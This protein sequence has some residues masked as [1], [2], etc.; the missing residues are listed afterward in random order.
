MAVVTRK[1]IQ[2]LARNW[3]FLV[4]LCRIF[5]N[6]LQYAKIKKTFLA[7]AD[8]ERHPNPMIDTL[9]M[10][11]K[12]TQNKKQKEL[13]D[14][15]NI[16]VSIQTIRRRLPEAGIQKWYAVKRALLNKSQATERLRWARE[17]RH[18][19]RD[20]FAK[21]LW[22]DESLVKKDNDSL[23]K[24]VFEARSFALEDNIAIPKPMP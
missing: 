16:G 5:F 4:E 18:W 13:R 21:V 2:R 14:I 8:L 1:R 17:H 12:L 11:L 24:R 22:M 9:L 23:R 10:K 7:L 15:T 6:A 20:D 19:T 3:T